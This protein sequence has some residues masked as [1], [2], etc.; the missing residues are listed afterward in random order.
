MIFYFYK[1][2]N[3]IIFFPI[4][5]NLSIN[6]VLVWIALKWNFGALAFL[7]AGPMHCWQDPQ[8]V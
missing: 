7:S 3:S 2:V 6:L 1:K 8:V 5:N 4:K